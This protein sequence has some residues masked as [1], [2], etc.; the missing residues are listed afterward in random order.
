MADDQKMRGILCVIGGCIIHLYLGCFYLWG[1]IQVYITSYLHKHD[2]S[3]TLDDTSTIFVLQGVF[4][5]IF[6][7]VAPFMLKH[8]PVW[9]LITVGG[10]FAIGGVFL[11]S[12]LTNVTYF[13][14]VYPLFY[15][16]GIG[17]TY[18]APLVCGWEYFPERRGAVSG[19]IVGGF[20]FGSFIFSYVSLLIVNPEGHQATQKVSGGMIFHPNDPVS[21]RAPLMLRVNCLCWLI[22]LI[23]S[24]ILIRRKR[25]SQEDRV[26]SSNNGLSSDHLIVSVEEN[27]E[28]VEPTYKEAMLHYRTLYIWVMIVLS[29]SYPMLMASHFKTYANIDVPDEKFLMIT[30]SFGAAMNGLSRGIWAYFQDIY[31]FKAVFLTLI[32]FQILIALTVDF[33]HKVKVLY[34]IWTLVTYFCLGGYFSIFPTVNAKLYGAVTGGKVH[35]TIFCAFSTSTILNLLLLRLE[36]SRHLEYAQIFYI[37]AGFSIIV[38]IMTILFDDA[39][40]IKKVL[41]RNKRF[42]QEEDSFIELKLEN[43]S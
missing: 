2:H 18:L 33:I 38:A 9:V 13:V 24:L 20:G 42:N 23:I 25:E 15:G 29:V 12:F 14:I 27:I 26:E 22:I 34:F 43:N 8:Y 3:V 36:S 31:G 4:Q 35:G 6:M 37:Q 39:T 28:I 19:V 1:H 10:V 7:P 21:S 32:I 41:R 17:I 40:L 30:G 11:T 16:F 5:A